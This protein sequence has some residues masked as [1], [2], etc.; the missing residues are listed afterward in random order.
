MSEGYVYDEKTITKGLLS[1]LYHDVGLIQ[2]SDDELGT[3]AKYTV[4]T[5]SVYSVM[6]EDLGDALSQDSIEDIADCIR[7]TILVMSPSK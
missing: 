6:R 3:G 2:T 4:D 1:A 5:K 7:C